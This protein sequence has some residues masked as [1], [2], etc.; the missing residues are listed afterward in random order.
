MRPPFS[1][2]SAAVRQWAP[3]AAAVAVLVT[4]LLPGAA[5]ASSSALAK[6]KPTT[7]QD[8]HLRE[9]Q[10]QREQVRSQKA[11][12]ASEVDTLNATDGEIKQALAD[13]DA[14]ISGETSRL[15]DAKRAESQA[16]ADEANAKTREATAAT[17]LDTL[18]T[19][20]KKQAVEAYTNSP[21]D[22]TF[23]VLSANDV[24][25]AASRNTLVEVQAQQNLDVVEHYRTVQQD[26]AIARTTAADAHQRAEDHRAEVAAQ[27]T[28]L[29][30]AQDAQQ[31]FAD[32]VENRIESS[33][34]EADSLSQLDGALA[35]QITQTQAAIAQEL[36]S[37]R[38]ARERRAKALGL[39]VRSRATGPDGPTPS[40]R[41]VGGNGIVTVG[42]I[43][44]DS[45][46]A[47]AL[48]SLL[49][50]AAADGVNL[51]GGG[52]R[53]PGQQISLRR[54]HC[55]S[56]NY[57]VYQA[58]ATSCSPPTARPGQSMHEQG[59]AI[60]FTMGGRTLSRSSPGY[61]WLKAHAA[62]YGLHNLP[63]EPWH[64]S[65]NGN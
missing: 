44:V 50:A 63:S 55:G 5:E 61:Q 21:P 40:F 48:Q 59:L 47:G 17:E 43:S 35:G 53:D 7:S 9:L 39:T 27:L 3:R 32:Q 51:G 22:E 45:S 12:K 31:K 18:H 20:I 38:A 41:N 58:P 62:S 37:Q 4:T 42:G 19:Q 16:E 8:G 29:E 14:N 26:L 60:D 24:L 64:W 52:F 46:I 30:Q 33:L 13:L 10:Q 23:G 34:A 57:A 1:T 28:K 36:E 25:E 56:S 49:S 6:G 15:E 11:K 65:T 2:A 54:A